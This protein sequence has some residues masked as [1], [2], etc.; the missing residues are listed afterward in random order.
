MKQEKL[1]FLYLRQDQPINLFLHADDDESRTE[2]PTEKRKRKAREEEGQVYLSNELPQSLIL[3]G[4][5]FFIF[6]FSNYYMKG[7]LEYLSFNF[8]NQ[9]FVL[10]DKNS[11]GVI[12]KDN[13]LIFLQYF[14]P[15]GLLVLFLV[16]SLTLL[17]T[18]FFFSTKN[19][20]F[21]LKKIA[22]TWKNFLEK[23][24]FSRTQ[25]I[26]GVKI[27]I[28]LIFSTAIVAFF[29]YYF[30]RDFIYLLYNDI[31]FSFIKTSNYIYQVSLYLGFFLL[32]ISYPDWLIQKSEFLRKLKMTVDEV[33]KENKELEGDPLIKQ[34]QRERAKEIASKEV[35]EKTSQADVVITNPTHYACAIEYNQLLMDAPRLV[36]KGVDHLAFRIKKIAQEK[37]IPIVENKP[38]ARSLY[39]E[40]EINEYIPKEFYSALAK[41]L[42]QLDKYKG[43]NS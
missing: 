40:V 35:I 13:I 36:S 34:K 32:V 8:I 1:P 3:I 24:I 6:V 41:I 29:L 27:I 7:F 21:N 18:R 15:I 42:A 20:K 23:T 14:F 25:V 43:G 26:N 37:N 30:T 39:E 28:K 38:L 10:I 33:K 12:I 5:V 19:L 16:V 9:D 4:V 2:Q 31:Y 17:Q 11:M 22:P